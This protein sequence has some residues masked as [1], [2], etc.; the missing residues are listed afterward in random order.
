VFLVLFAVK[1]LAEEPRAPSRPAATRYEIECSGFVTA[2]PVSKEIYVSGGADNDLQA[3]FRQYAVEGLV[4]LHGKATVGTEYRLV[5]SAKQI[6]TTQSYAGQRASLRTLGHPYEDVGR[7]KVASLTPRGAVAE[8]TFACGPV[9]PGD[10]AV[11]YQTRPIPEYTPI[12]QLDRFALTSGKQQGV[13]T[14]A[15]NNDAFLGV[16]SIAYL[17]LGSTDGVRP[18]QRYRVFH[19]PRDR[20]AN[21]LAFPPETPVESLGEL[22]I[23]FTQEKSS[24]AIVVSSIR[25]ISVGDGIEAE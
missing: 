12:E 1:G 4:Y 8:V 19:I 13:I 25:E 10:I 14:A 3:A 15:R 9:T 18:G 11:P 24:V 22:V 6:F 17:N 7:V 21:R 16:G 23:L 5:R 20:I 2:A